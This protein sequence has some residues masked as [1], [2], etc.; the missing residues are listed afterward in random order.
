[1]KRFKLLI[2]RRICVQISRPIPGR[3]VHMTSKQ[4]R[5]KVDATSCRQNYVVSRSMRRNDTKTTS[6][7]GRCDIMTSNNVVLRSMLHHDVETTSYKGRCYVMTSHRRCKIWVSAWTFLYKAENNIEKIQ[8]VHGSPTKIMI[9]FEV[10][11][12][13]VYSIFLYFT[14]INKNELLNKLL[15]KMHA[16]ILFCCHSI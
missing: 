16:I 14:D 10:A 3:Y 6:F 4:R 11:L 12:S 9:F 15:L 8:P 13:M 5:I 2:K 7:K 1:M